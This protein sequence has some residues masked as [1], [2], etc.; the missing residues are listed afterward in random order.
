MELVGTEWPVG[1]DAQEKGPCAGSGDRSAMGSCE[2]DRWEG[3]RMSPLILTCHKTRRRG[4]VPRTWRLQPEV[5]CQPRSMSR[6]FGR[7][8]PWVLGLLV[9]WAGAPCARAQF[10]SIGSSSPLGTGTTLGAGTQG[11]RFGQANFSSANRNS[12]ISLSQRFQSDSNRF[13]MGSQALGQTTAGLG[14]ANGLF[15]GNANSGFNNFFNMGVFSS[16]ARGG[17]GRG[18]NNR[19]QQNTANQ[20]RVRARLVKAFR[21]P[22]VPARSRALSQRLSRLMSR[23]LPDR[24][25]DV[26]VRL[27]QGVAVL[28]GTVASDHDRR[29]VELLVKMEPGVASVQNQIQVASSQPPR[30]SK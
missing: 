19:M 2:G 13:Q 12:G 29:V 25:K 9:V 1:V 17:F 14:A 3:N 21:S 23:A 5:L 28:T 8:W 30:S 6:T 4:A 10:G 24:A 26:E 7:A 15:G 18:M 27:D 16:L 22:A 20:R 11:S